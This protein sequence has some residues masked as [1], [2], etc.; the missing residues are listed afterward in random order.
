MGAG[1]YTD[2]DLVKRV[3]TSHSNQQS[4]YEDLRVVKE[5]EN[6]LY[7]RFV[8]YLSAAALGV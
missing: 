4:I 1:L 2:A 3:F 7:D 5:Q 8:S 6:S